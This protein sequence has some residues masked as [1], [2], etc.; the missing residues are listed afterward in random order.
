MNI[1]DIKLRDYGLLCLIII[2]VKDGC[3][4]FERL[5]ARLDG[6]DDN[7]MPR[8]ASNQ[9]IELMSLVIFLGSDSGYRRSNLL[10]TR[11]R[12][13]FYQ[14]RIN[15]QAKAA[16]FVIIVLTTYRALAYVKNHTG[17]RDHRV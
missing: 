7:D 11:C 6:Y 13:R 16:T 10:K 4:R 3:S 2:L 8:M 12:L 9:M 5:R 14:P 1:F 15:G 17:V